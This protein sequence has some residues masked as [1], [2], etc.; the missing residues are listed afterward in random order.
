MAGY[1]VARLAE[2]RFRDVG[3]PRMGPIRW[4]VD[5]FLVAAT[6]A[7][8]AGCPSLREVEDLLALKGEHRTMFKLIEESLD[9]SEVMAETVDVLDNHTTVM[10]RL[11]LMT[12]Q[13]N[14]AYGDGKGSNESVWR[15]ARTF[16]RGVRDSSEEQALRRR[17]QRRLA[18]RAAGDLAGLAESDP[19]G[20]SAPRSCI[21]GAGSDAAAGRLC[22]NA[23][24]QEGPMARLSALLFLASL[25]PACVGILQE[26]DDAQNPAEAGCTDCAEDAGL[27]LSD[28][29]LST[30]T[31]AGSKPSDAGPSAG[32]RTDAGSALDAG[33][34]SDADLEQDAGPSQDVG[35]SRDAGPSQDAGSSQDTGVG[36]DAGPPADAGGDTFMPCPTNGSA[37]RIMPLGDSITDGVGSPQGGGYRI[38]LFRLSVTDKKAITFVG[39]SANG[40][41][42]VEGRAF[43]RNH[44][45]HSGFTIDTTS[46]RSGIYPLVQ[47][48]LS[49][50]QPH[51]VLLMIGTNDVGVGADLA[52]AP[53]RLGLLLDRITNTSPN[54]LLVVAKIVPSTDDG[55]NNKIRSYNDGVEQV[56]N[57]RISAG[58]HLILIDLYKRFT[59]HP[60]YKSDWMADY[61]H[62]NLNGYSAMASGWYPVIKPLLPASQ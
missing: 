5:Q 37:C 38:E 19:D 45:G 61:L 6:A 8:M 31:D 18:A 15:H 44:E 12:A 13:Q 56:V 53:N 33:H 22:R 4:R 30:D 41:S 27:S 51:I 1:L 57:Q 42:N 25:V 48:A 49:T 7:A 16:L 2:A 10:R 3:D 24:L 60:N 36:E 52:N 58:K 50:H 43:P 47:Q 54:A 9:P 17:L 35:S 59:D 40:P 29:G 46:G 20:T 14:W 32:G 23:T 39:S 28:S 26:S 11:V 55:M 34:A 62:P 21:I